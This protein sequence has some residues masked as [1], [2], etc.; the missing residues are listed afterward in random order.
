MGG[1]CPAPLLALLLAMLVPGVS[2]AEDH[3]TCAAETF[4]T[5]CRGGGRELRIIEDTASPS[6]QYGIAWEVPAEARALKTDSDGSKH[7]D[8]GAADNFLVR[9]DAGTVV[10]KLE[11]THYGDHARYNHFEVAAVWSPDSRFVAAVYQSKWM[12]DAAVIFRLSAE[13]TAGK[14]LDL[15]PICREVNGSREARLRGKSGENYEHTVDVHAVGKDATI[16]A[17]CGMQVIK[18]DNYFAFA[19]R[20]KLDPRNDALTARVIGARRCTNDLGP[21]A[22]R[23]PH[24]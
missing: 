11:G 21:C 24:E 8:G 20:L 5:V 13:G 1:R 9:L 19:I 15:L 16:S 10:T 23:E 22:E 14:P 3:F 17:K 12:T 2:A 7:F 6:R 18:Q 4:T